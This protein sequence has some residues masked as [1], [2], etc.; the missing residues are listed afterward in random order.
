MT[1]TNQTKP[2]FV[3]ELE[4]AYGV[5]SQAAFGSAVFYNE[6]EAT[7]DLEKSAFETYRYFVGD[8]WERFG[9]EASKGRKHQHGPLPLIAT[10][11]FSMQSQAFVA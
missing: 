3:I 2:K 7:D 11:V 9:E 10:L 6:M 1:S 4:A 5:P 8:L